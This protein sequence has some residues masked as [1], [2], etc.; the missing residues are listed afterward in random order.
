MQIE[1]CIWSKKKAIDM[2]KNHLS[3][4]ILVLKE[5]RSLCDSTY[6]SILLE[7]SGTVL[8]GRL[9]IFTAR[10][11]DDTGH[12]VVKTPLLTYSVVSY[13]QQ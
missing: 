4:I 2:E 13:Q 10:V 6:C 11:P 9:A 5:N 3:M 12:S 7:V 1:G 8:A